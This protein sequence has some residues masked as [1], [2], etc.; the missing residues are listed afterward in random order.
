MAPATTLTDADNLITSRLIG[1]SATT[2]L[3]STN[4]CC[5]CNRNWGTASSN[6]C[7]AIASFQKAAVT[8]NDNS[9]VKIV[10]SEKVRNRFYIPP[11]HYTENR[12]YMNQACIAN[13]YYPRPRKI[14]RPPYYG[15]YNIEYEKVYDCDNQ[16]LGPNWQGIAHIEDNRIMGNV[17]VCD[18]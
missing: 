18:L 10:I 1:Y 8:H 6:H 9:D 2:C 11:A 7:F 5:H 15:L 17:N 13:K 12:F 16:I 4:R 3:Y 14:H